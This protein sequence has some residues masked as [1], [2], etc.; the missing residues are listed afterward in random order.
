M[1]ISRF[2]SS[3]LFVILV[4]MAS[5]PVGVST[6]PDN[7]T[8]EFNF[9]ESGEIIGVPY[10]WQEVNGFCFPSALSMVLQSMRLDLSLYDILAASGSGFSM[11][12][13]SVDETM[14]FLPGVMVRQLPWFEFFT[15][16]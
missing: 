1:R 10:V 13:I 12:S 4:S 16:W 9:S 7:P 5:L 6:I 15:D 2:S 14:M 3:I 8:L 11:V